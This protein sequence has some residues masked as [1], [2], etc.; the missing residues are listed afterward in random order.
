MKKTFT[1]VAA[2][3]TLLLTVSAT[4][5]DTSGWYTFPKGESMNNDPYSAETWSGCLK[6][7]SCSRYEGKDRPL[8]YVKGSTGGYEYSSDDENAPWNPGGGG[9][10]G[11]M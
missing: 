9:G 6:V 11:G 4:T 1:L 7:R 2:T 8:A 10:G 3:A 5:A